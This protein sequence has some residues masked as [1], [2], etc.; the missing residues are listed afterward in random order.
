MGRITQVAKPTNHADQLTEC[1]TIRYY[2]DYLRF[3]NISIGD[4]T[5]TSIVSS[6]LSTILGMPIGSHV[7][8]E[9][10]WV[11]FSASRPV[12]ADASAGRSHGRIY[13]WPAVARATEFNA[14]QNLLHC[15]LL[16]V[17]W[18]VESQIEHSTGIAD[19]RSQSTTR[20]QVVKTC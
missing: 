18:E 9:A 1:G 16:A 10:H 7:R 5:L 20:G 13:S 8:A 3:Q 2:H 19:Q 14:L 17:S 15:I 6:K 12:H 11:V 4:S